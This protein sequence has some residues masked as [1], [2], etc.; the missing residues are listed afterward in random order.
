MLSPIE[1]VVDAKT[2]ERLLAHDTANGKYEIA[3]IRKR[4]MMPRR[5]DQ[6]VGGPGMEGGLQRV[7][8][9]RH[10]PAIVNILV[11]QDFHHG[12]LRFSGILKPHPRLR[13]R[14]QWSAAPRRPNPSAAAPSS[15]RRSPGHPPARR[16]G[17]GRFRQN[18]A[19]GRTVSP[20]D[21]RR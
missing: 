12:T 4:R 1:C 8:R 7:D 21:F 14:G 10:Q 20:P 11:H 13:S 9:D 19:A 18:L 5:R 17:H 15:H 3:S 16:R 2:R 6:P